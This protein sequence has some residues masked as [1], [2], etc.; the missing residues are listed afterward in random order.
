[1]PCEP[2]EPGAFLAMNG[3]HY[4]RTPVAI[5]VGAPLAGAWIHAPAMFDHVFDESFWT[6]AARV[7]VLVLDDVGLEPQDARVRDRIV[8]LLVGRYDAARRTIVTTN[9]NGADF[10]KTYASGA[11]ERLA[12]R[13]GGGSWFTVRP[14]E[15]AA[16][17]AP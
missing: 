11:G 6:A 12:A 5:G 17:A 3:Q 13:L 9:L 4:V 7:P 8:G 15:S 14:I 1:M 16:R 2:N 10:R